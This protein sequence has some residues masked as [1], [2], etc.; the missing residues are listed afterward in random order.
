MT[1]DKKENWIRKIQGL[2]N[3][4]TENGATEA[5]AQSAMLMA[6]K[7]MA[8]HGLDMADIDTE[9]EKVEKE[10]AEEYGNDDGR[11]S[12]WHS[13]LARV[14]ADNFRCYFFL[15]S[16]YK[17]TRVVFMG[18]KEDAE[19][20]RSVFKFASAQIEH[21]ARMYRKK[22]KKELEEEKL[23]T[24][25]KEFSLDEVIEYAKEVGV[26]EYIIDAILRRYDKNS[27][28]RK[29][30]T[31]EIKKSLN[32]KINGTALR[33][34]Y[35]T[36]FIDGLDSKFA[37]QVEQNKEEWGLVL[38]KDGDLVEKYNELSKSFK[39]ARASTYSTSGD[40]RA[41]AAGVKQGRKFE[42]V[43]GELN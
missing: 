30:L 13:S 22:R 4:T 32:I 20:A 19:V 26:S 16:G 14:I 2:L 41:Y 25:F 36:G 34:D 40:D 38:V 24:N 11:L 7:L 37:E 15:R 42:Q 10:I 18:L 39:S 1:K 5:E 31:T 28:I 33:N 3:K 12:W 35:I 17:R 27:M 8:K 29:Y 6:Q 9:H 23:P 43:R 21:H